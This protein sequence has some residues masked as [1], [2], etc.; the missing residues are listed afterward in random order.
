MKLFHKIFLCFMLIFGITFQT[1]GF[2]L[3]DF[4]SRNAISQE[5]K[6]AFQDFQYNKYILQS[7]PNPIFLKRK[8][9]SLRVFQ[10]IL[11]FL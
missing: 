1:A 10:V 2:L 4:A 11:L 7:I 5:K 9:L 8:K 3:I 6:Y